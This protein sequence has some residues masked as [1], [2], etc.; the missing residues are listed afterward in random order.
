[1]EVEPAS[2]SSRPRQSWQDRRGRGLAGSTLACAWL[3]LDPADNDLVRFGRYL[4]AA[5]FGPAGGAAAAA[6]LFGPGTAPTPDLLGATLL[7]TVAASDGAFVLVLGDY[8]AVNAEPI[9]RLVRFLIE[10]GPPFVH[11]SS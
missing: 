5:R 3:S 6:N 8:H 11:P 7:D 9:H 4:A 2:R 1:L 10:R